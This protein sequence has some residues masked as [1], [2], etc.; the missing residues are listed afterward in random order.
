MK[1]LLHFKCIHIFTATVGYMNT[2]YII[3]V[4]CASLETFTAGPVDPLTI[5]FLY[6]ISEFRVVTL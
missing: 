4:V 1:K 6:R 2:S 5:Y 3:H